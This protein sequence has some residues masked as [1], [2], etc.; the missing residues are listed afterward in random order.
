MSG[1]QWVNTSYYYHVK[2][3]G[4]SLCNNLITVLVRIL[5]VANWAKVVTYLRP[6]VKIVLSL[7]SRD[8][9]PLSCVHIK[10]YLDIKRVKNMPHP[11]PAKNLSKVTSKKIQNQSVIQKCEL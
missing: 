2:R 9:W 1:I 5:I 7:K 4:D 11:T 10:H 6:L 3:S 8:S